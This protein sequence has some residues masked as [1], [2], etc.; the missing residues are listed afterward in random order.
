LEPKSGL[1]VLCRVPKYAFGKQAIDASGFNDLMA[2][3]AG[4]I[5]IPFGKK[6]IAYSAAAVNVAAIKNDIVEAFVKADV[7]YEY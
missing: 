7:C 5:G 1:C 6:Y 3:K 4:L 2:K